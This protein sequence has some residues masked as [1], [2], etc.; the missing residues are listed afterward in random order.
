[1]LLNTDGGNGCLH[2]IALRCPQNLPFESSLAFL[3]YNRQLQCYSRFVKGH[4]L[5][6]SCEWTKQLRK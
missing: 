2:A 1:M 5:P 4:S 3:Q 6:L